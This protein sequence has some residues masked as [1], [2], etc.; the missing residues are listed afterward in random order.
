MHQYAV[1]NNTYTSPNPYYSSVM[2]IDCLPRTSCEYQVTMGLQL[3]GH[4]GILYIVFPQILFN[5][6]DFNWAITLQYAGMGLWVSEPAVNMLLGLH[7]RKKYQSRGLEPQ[8]VWSNKRC[9]KSPEDP[10]SSCGSRRQTSIL[11]G[12][13]GVDWIV[14]SLCSA[15]STVWGMSDQ[16]QSSFAR[17]LQVT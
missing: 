1:Q 7:K 16:L 4:C 8:T 12:L 9:P 10:G 13:Q 5:D 14:W 15:G 11:C 17:G 2:L 6:P 3:F